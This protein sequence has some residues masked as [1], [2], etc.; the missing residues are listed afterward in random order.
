LDA[1]AANKQELVVSTEEAADL[2]EVLFQ[3]K[4]ASLGLP[5][6]AVD[7][8]DFSIGEAV[9]YDSVTQWFSATVVAVSKGSLTLQSS[10]N[11][12][13]YP[14]RDV[15][16]SWL[17]RDWLHRPYNCPCRRGL[18]VFITQSHGH[19]CLI[20]EVQLLAGT[21]MHGCRI[22][23][24]DVCKSCLKA[25]PRPS[26]EFLDGNDGKVF[27]ALDLPGTLRVSDLR[28]HLEISSETLP[29][30]SIGA[31]V[32]VAG[33]QRNSNNTSRS[34]LVV[35]KSSGPIYAAGLRVGDEFVFFNGFH[36]RSRPLAEML[37]MIV[38]ACR[39]DQPC[40][41][42]VS[43]PDPSI[44]QYTDRFFDLLVRMF[45]RDIPVVVRLLCMCSN[46]S[47][48]DFLDSNQFYQSAKAYFKDLELH[49]GESTLNVSE[50]YR[51]FEESCKIL[52][53]GFEVSSFCC[54]QVCNFYAFSKETLV[55]EKFFGLLTCCLLVSDAVKNPRVFEAIPHAERAIYV[56]NNG[57]CTRRASRNIVAIPRLSGQVSRSIQLIVASPVFQNHWR[58][59][60]LALTLDDDGNMVDALELRQ[61]LAQLIQVKPWVLREEHCESFL[62]ILLKDGKLSAELYEQAFRAAF[63]VQNAPKHFC[64]QDV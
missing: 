5:S 58:E 19:F 6:G 54:Q 40:K 56:I 22:C 12:A 39:F 15:D 45:H 21:K 3:F 61:L 47:L 41:L 30:R 59:K 38:S 13:T 52:A 46:N 20:C 55:F 23:D 4:H 57:L 31:E 48:S 44:A 18:C 32:H 33:V 36:C 53:R 49:H 27:V 24:F 34:C 10:M 11:D 8:T 42:T 50:V 7:A 51:T 17:A 14:L 63:L 1:N 25:P 37:A 2:S 26:G 16:P 35:M 9:W 28:S 60:F 43:R 29:C 62:N 64:F